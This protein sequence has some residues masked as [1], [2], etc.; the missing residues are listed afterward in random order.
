MLFCHC[1]SFIFSS[2]AL[3]GPRGEEKSGWAGG[4]DPGPA[5]HLKY[6]TNETAEGEID[7]LLQKHQSRDGPGSGQAHSPAGPFV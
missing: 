4:R 2:S 6:E 3:I 7:I 1:V 5:I